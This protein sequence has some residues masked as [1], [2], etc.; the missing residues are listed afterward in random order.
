LD[1]EHSTLEGRNRAYKIDRNKRDDRYNEGD[2][3][4][5]LRLVITH[6][7]LKDGGGKAPRILRFLRFVI[8]EGD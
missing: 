2:D 3:K 1:G 8:N 4:L 6:D 7:G 5:I